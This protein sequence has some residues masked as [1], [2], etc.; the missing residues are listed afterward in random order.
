MS[1]LNEFIKKEQE[2]IKKK[3][4]YLDKLIKI[5]NEFPDLEYNIDRWKKLRLCSPSVNKIAKN[6]DIHHGCRCC[7]DSPL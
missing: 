7:S 3:T 6:V 4:E 2:E 5:R 1:D